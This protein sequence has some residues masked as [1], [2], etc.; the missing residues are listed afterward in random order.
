MHAENREAA[1]A[2]MLAALDAFV[3]EGPK[4]TLLPF[5][6]ALLATDKWA[7][8]RTAREF[9]TNPKALMDKVAE[10]QATTDTT[11]ST[12]PSHTATVGNTST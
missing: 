7:S 1:T 3:L 10:A 4:A 11:E 9:T 12:R 5:Q 8:A 2:K 6:R